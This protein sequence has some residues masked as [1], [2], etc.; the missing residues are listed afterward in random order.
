M[1]DFKGVKGEFYGLYRDGYRITS[2]LEILN[3]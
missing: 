1:D 2:N 3:G